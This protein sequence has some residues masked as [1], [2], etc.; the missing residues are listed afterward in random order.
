MWLCLSLSYFWIARTIF[1]CNSGT[2]HP[3]HSL[4]RIDRRRIFPRGSPVE[5]YTL[6]TDR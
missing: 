2:I 1:A 4:T 3:V 6:Q 5:A